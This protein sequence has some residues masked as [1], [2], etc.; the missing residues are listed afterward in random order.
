MKRYPCINLISGPRNISTALMYSF[1]QRRDLQVVDE[2]FYAYYLLQSQKEHPGREETLQ[3]QPHSFAAVEQDLNK[4]MTSNGLFIK[5]MAHHMEYLPLSW[6]L[7][8]KNVFLI[9][10]PAALIAS[11]AQVITQPDMQDIGLAMEEKLFDDL[12]E[13]TGTRQIVLDSGEVLKNPEAVLKKLCGQLEIDWDKSMLQ[14]EP[15]ARKE[16]G[17]WAKYWYKNVHQSS[18]FSPQRKTRRPI[19]EQCQ[20]LYEKALPIYNK[21]FE[22]SI[23][24]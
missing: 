8:F 2:P 4:I 1:A 18:G 22:H 13:K 9:R 24:A 5:N 23:K 14:W 19:P 3:S 6:A 20:E 7:N 21:L 15:G 16:D 10:D 12:T 17:V 11:F